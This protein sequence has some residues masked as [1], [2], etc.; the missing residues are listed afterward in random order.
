[1]TL[2]ESFWWKG[3]CDSPVLQHCP[4]M[5]CYPPTFPDPADLGCCNKLSFSHILNPSGDGSYCRNTALVL[6]LVQ[7][8]ILGAHDDS[9]LTYCH[10]SSH[11]ELLHHSPLAR[12]EEVSVGKWGHW[13]PLPL[14]GWT[15]ICWFSR[16]PPKA[17]FW[18]YLSFLG[19]YVS[20]PQKKGS[21]KKDFWRCH[22]FPYWTGYFLTAEIEWI[23]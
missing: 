3:Q 16:A 23:C 10:S 6:A 17:K 1:M 21:I 15:W 9:P 19:Q 2:W 22:T 4:S 14:P 5:G 8:V 7:G 11:Q 18:R 20:A 12:N 13:K